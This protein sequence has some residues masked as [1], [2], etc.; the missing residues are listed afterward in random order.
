[1]DAYDVRDGAVAEWRGA[2]PRLE[3]AFGRFRMKTGPRARTRTIA[4]GSRLGKARCAA[5]SAPRAAPLALL[6]RDPRDTFTV[7]LALFTAA[8]L[9]LFAGGALALFVGA[10]VVLFATPSIAADDVLRRPPPPSTRNAVRVKRPIAGGGD[11]AIVRAL[12]KVGR[13]IRGDAQDYDA[14]LAAFGDA[15]IVLLGEDTHGTH[16]HYVERARIMERLVGDHGFAAVVIEGDAV[17]AAIASRALATPGSDFRL[18]HGLSAFDRFPSW[19]WRNDEF[20]ALL[21]R[22]R[23]LNL[24]PRGRES[25]V[26]LAGMDLYDLERPA[27]VVVDHLESI[28]PRLAA[29]ARDR[30]RCFETIGWNPQ[31]YGEIL[32]RSRDACAPGDPLTD[33]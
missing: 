1:M 7:S 20:I 30:Y 11:A 32:E 24:D 27:A 9:V 16:E 19:M 18:V 8:S 14:L 2:S 25:R 29:A 6:A 33:F 23:A 13:P 26:M 31:R 4:N 17:P 5:S 28:D 22:L 3:Q 12:A 21:A 15:R 10:S